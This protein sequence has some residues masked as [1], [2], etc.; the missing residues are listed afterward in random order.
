MRGL[1]VLADIHE[2][3]KERGII[4][5]TMRS[6]SLRRLLKRMMCMSA[7]TVR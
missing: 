5:L 3:Q 2:S 4:L 6:S 1:A 7:Q